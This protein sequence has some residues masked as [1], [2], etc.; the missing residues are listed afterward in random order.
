MN[1]EQRDRVHGHLTRSPSRTILDGEGEEE[2]EGRLH[3]HKK[4]TPS[5]SPPPVDC[6]NNTTAA[7]AAKNS[8]TNPSLRLMA[9]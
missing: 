6:P 4:C 2:Y 7:A 1:K 5:S 8:T 3:L 9:S